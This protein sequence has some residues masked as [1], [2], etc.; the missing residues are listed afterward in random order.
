MLKYFNTK[1]NC[2]YII[3]LGHKYL[4]Y[5]KKISYIKSF[6][7]YHVQCAIFTICE[8]YTC[9]LCCSLKAYIKVASFVTEFYDFFLKTIYGSEWKFMFILRMGIDTHLIL[10]YVTNS[11]F[12]S[13]I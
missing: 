1:P 9:I 3:Y 11:T 12:M 6:H 5:E 7:D 13:L 4:S 8:K 10:R 2:I